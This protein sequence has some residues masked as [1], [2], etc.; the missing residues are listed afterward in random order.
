MT[1]LPPSFVSSI[2]RR[3]EPLELQLFRSIDS[4]GPLGVMCAAYT[5]GLNLHVGYG[6][7]GI[8]PGGLRD[9]KRR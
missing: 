8:P 4:K 2:D 3:Q 1:A 7:K 9:M 6:I 5:M